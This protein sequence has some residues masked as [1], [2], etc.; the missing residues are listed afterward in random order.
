M[1]AADLGAMIAR[2]GIPILLSAVVDDGLFFP[3]S[4]RGF[5]TGRLGN[6]FRQPLAIDAVNFLIVAKY[7]NGNLSPIEGAGTFNL[8][9]Q[10]HCRFRMG[11]FDLSSAF[12]P[13]WNYGTVL[14]DGI[15]DASPEMQSVNYIVGADSLTILS[16]NHFRWRLPR[17]LYV[18]PGD[19][20]APTISWPTMPNTL[21]RYPTL[22]NGLNYVNVHISYAARRLPASMAAPREIDVP[23]VGLFEP[24]YVQDGI[25]GTVGQTA[26]S[27]AADLGNPFERPLCVQR[28]L[29]RINRVGNNSSSEA[30][31]IIDSSIP[32]EAIGAV[33]I[34]AAAPFKLITVGM[35]DSQGYAIVRQDISWRHVFDVNR[36]AWTFVRNLAAKE[37]YS[38][39]LRG[40]GV[41]GGDVDENDYYQPQISMV[42]WR[43]E[44]L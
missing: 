42:G 26:S 14:Q 13:I 37:W 33:N 10:I 6:V 16:F 9:G 21:A 29:G 23:Y 12:V 3:G 5:D 7:T 44:A 40:L 32:P 30:H 34:E 15:E 28:F 38:V 18:P 27:S 2:G 25:N 36:R 8:G 24:A 1:S 35:Q 41:R 39:Q 4:T 17:P 11:S 19:C 31:Y 20:L 22:S 43:R